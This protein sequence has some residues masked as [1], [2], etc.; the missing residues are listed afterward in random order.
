MLAEAMSVDS[1]THKQ[2]ASAGPTAQQATAS[3]K[4]SQVITMDTD[5]ETIIRRAK[6]VKSR[7]RGNRCSVSHQRAATIV[8]TFMETRGGR[9][10]APH[11]MVGVVHRNFGCDPNVVGR[12]S[13]CPQPQQID[14]RS[15]TVVSL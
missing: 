9:P 8:A 10:N 3:P 11:N 1:L 5:L 2:Y 4:G 12:G 14:L 7:G 15:D 6:S 13:H